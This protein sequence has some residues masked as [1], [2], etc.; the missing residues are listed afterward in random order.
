MS[1]I[2]TEQLLAG[3]IFGDNDNDEYVYMPG[4]EVGSENPMCTFECKDSKT[5]LHMKEAI[6]TIHSL[7]LK[8]VK[9]PTLGRKSY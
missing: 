6:E 8:P 1:I 3:V 5:D 4:G 2:T 7:S 9:H